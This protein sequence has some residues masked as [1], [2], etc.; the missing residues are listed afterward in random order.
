MHYFKDRRDAGRKLAQKLID[1][2]AQADVLIVALP[3]GGVPVGYEISRALS[4]PL[5]IFLVRKLGVPSHP[6]YAM[7]A[8]ASG[9]VRVL[10]EDVIRTLGISD[11]E[12][13]LTAAEEERELNRRQ[14]SYRQGAGELPHTL[15][16][17]TIILVDDGM[18]TGATTEAAAIAL[19]SRN[20]AELILAV[21]VAS[22]DACN[23]L[24]KKVDRLVIIATP[25][26]FGAV[27]AWY[28]DFGQTTDEEVID[29]LSKARHAVSQ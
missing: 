25:E 4:A 26:P 27:G 22:V 18:A 20:P 28:E 2:S 24:R 16:G 1:Y 13:A 8:I 3:R 21:P 19:R 12:I 5:D 9:G 29:I 17:Q 11:S 14:R 23:K 7:G 15:S 10:N 6:E